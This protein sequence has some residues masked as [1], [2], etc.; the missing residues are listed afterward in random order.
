MRFVASFTL[1]RVVLVSLCLG[2]VARAAEAEYAVGDVLEP[3]KISDAKGGSFD[4]Q[5]GF[6]ACL[7]VSYEM[8]PGKAV[9][10]YLAAKPADYLETHRA[11]FIANIHG[12]PAIGRFFA[13][14]KMEKYPHRILL[15]DSETLLL[16]HPVKADRVTV[17]TLDAAGAITAIRHLDPAKE[18]DQLFETPKPAVAAPVAP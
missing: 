18:L 14:P 15:G 9:N 10:G 12:M 2:L 8:S 4:Y 1:L 6:L 13:L 11:A 16:R 3:F 5:P 7:I 17:F